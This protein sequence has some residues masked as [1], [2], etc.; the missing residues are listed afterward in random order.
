MA[1]PIQASEHFIQQIIRRDCEAGLHDGRVGTRFPPEPNGYLHLGHAKS[2]CLNF[3]L[4]AAFG[5]SCNLRFDDTNPENED[6]EYVESIREDVAWL[7]FKWD[8]ECYASDYFSQLY[9][10]A[11]KLIDSGKA[12]VCDLSVEQIS[13]Y[14]GTLTEP[15]R[16][17]PHRDRSPE[18]NKRLFEAMREGAFADGEKVLRAKIDMAHPNLSMRDPVMY[19]IKR[20]RHDRTGDCWPIY[21]SYDFAHGQSDSIERITHSL[22]TLEFEI[23]RPLY[24][25]FIRE[26][27]IFPSRQIEFAR[28]NLSYTIM[29]KRKLM[30]LV[31]EGHVCG[32]DDPRLPTLRGLRRRGYPPEAIRDFCETIG[33][34]KY[35]GV[36]DIALLEHAVRNRLNKTA[37]RVMAVLDPLKV[38]LT[39]FGDETAKQVE[40]QNNPENPDDGSR[41]LPFT[42][43]FYIERGDFMEDAPKKFFRLAPGR[44][45]RLRH[46]YIIRC[47]DVVRN[48]SGEV[49]EL[50]CT[51]DHAT[52]GSNPVDRKVKGVIH[53]VSAE[54]AVEAEV[55]LY[56]RLFSCERPEKAEQGF[57]SAL[58]PDSLTVLQA[59]VEPSLAEASPGQS[60]QFERIGYFCADSDS[61]RSLPVFNRTVA[62]RD[63][64]AKHA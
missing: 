23:H 36:T 14:R 5:G 11:L 57:L 26:L 44:E 41:M 45:V 49:I 50:R 39:N 48:D 32:W 27:D 24:E 34:T 38:T 43:E 7:G 29:S 9:E 31:R 13:E 28:L 55:R 47:D 37:P 20:A 17:S 62:L 21:P 15:G 25:W 19:R 35:N 51:L 40:A 61:S 54:H 6:V 58:N 12:Y 59:W 56:D 63:S 10:F 33:I 3:G 18:E 22:C 16:P 46:A 64:W 4:A 1:D 2:I 52:L 60:F 8:R 42:R 53:W 30:Q